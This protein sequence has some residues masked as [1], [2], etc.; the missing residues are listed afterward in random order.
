FDLIFFN[1][2]LHELPRS[3]TRALLAEACRVLKPGGL[4]A[5]H[6]FHLR[7][8][9]PFQNVLQRSHAYTNNETY[10]IPWYDTDIVAIGREAGFAA[11]SVEPFARLNRSVHRPGRAPISANHWNLYQF[12]K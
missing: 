2:M 7:P 5:G 6:E 10:S 8:N 11:V 9:D 4:F 1:F 12:R 3:H